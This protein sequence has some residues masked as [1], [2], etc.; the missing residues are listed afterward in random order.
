VWD[1]TTN[2]VTACST[3]TP[4]IVSTVA[5]SGGS[6]SN[7]TGSTTDQNGYGRTLFEASP[8][9][10]SRTGAGGVSFRWDSQTQITVVRRTA[11]TTIQ[12][13]RS[14]NRGKSYTQISSFAGGFANM[15]T[16]NGP[17]LLTGGRYIA[18]FSGTGV[19]AP[20]IAFSTN[21]LA[22]TAAAGSDILSAAGNVAISS[23]SVSPTSS[24]RLNAIRVNTG[25]ATCAAVTSVNGG[26]TWTNSTT[27]FACGTAPGEMN[28]VGGTTWL[29]QLGNNT[30]R[31]STDDGATWTPTT[32]VGAGMTAFI[33]VPPAAAPSGGLGYCL[34]AA[35]GANA[36]S[37]FRTTNAGATWTSVVNA[38]GLNSLFLS[39]TDYGSNIL[40]LITDQVGAVVSL[41][42]SEDAGFTWFPSA[43]VAYTGGSTPTAYFN[44]TF[45]N[46]LTRGSPSNLLGSAVF[47][48]NGIGAT[49]NPMYSQKLPAASGQ[50]VGSGGTAWTIDNAGRGVVA[51]QQSITLA[52]TQTT[53]AAATV[54][55]VNFTAAADQRW[56]IRSVEARCGTAAD[57]S[58]IVIESPVGTTIW[59]S[60]AA[61]V[62]STANFVRSWDFGLT[63]ATN[64]AGR[65]TL[66]ACT[67]GTG[68]LILQV[69]RAPAP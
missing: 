31:V 69:D 13:W 16:F 45:N 22:W 49:Q 24:L 19:N 18:S 25:D 38:T 50:I 47:I 67:V 12:L 3:T 40:S 17:L 55:V 6:A 66:A 54:V 60:H 35:G 51:G 57:T 52:N 20:A 10:D 23:M 5:G 27:P 62:I 21:L 68:T 15:G 46:N 53:G 7:P 9:F 11:A 29:W 64:V 42:R 36:Q 39:F 56:V 48:P 4:L 2:R 58:G 65:V 43:T 26:S 63:L 1:T 32:S 30:A 37:I 34:A 14:T 28:Y 44:G 61:A 8:S 59:S 33:C 41:W